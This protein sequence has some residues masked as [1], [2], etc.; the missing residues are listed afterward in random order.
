MTYSYNGFK[1]IHYLPISNWKRTISQTP[2]YWNIVKIQTKQLTKAPTTQT[3]ITQA[4]T[5]EPTLDNYIDVILLEIENNFRFRK[6][7]YSDTK[8][9]NTITTMINGVLKILDDTD[10]DYI[11][12]RVINEIESKNFKSVPDTYYGGENGFQEV[13]D[14]LEK[15]CSKIAT[16]IG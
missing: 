16:Q 14:L 1:Y 15:A 3:P 8:M 12:E 10:Y 9:Y 6:D 5:Q 13:Y 11:Y 4:P 2:T 7:E